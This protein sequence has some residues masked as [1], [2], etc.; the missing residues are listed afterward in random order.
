[1]KL[2][3]TLATS[4]LLCAGLSAHAGDIDGNA[5]LGGMPVTLQAA[6]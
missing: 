2:I 3:V 4:T 1:M 5:V 6:S